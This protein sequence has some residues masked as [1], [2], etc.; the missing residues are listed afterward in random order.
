MFVVF[1]FV[2]VVFESV[3]L[4]VFVVFVFVFVVFVEMTPR[5]RVVT[6]LKAMHERKKLLSRLTMQIKKQI[7]KKQTVRKQQKMWK[8][9]YLC[10]EGSL[11][12]KKRK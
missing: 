8:D 1:V 5:N 4:D 10:G 12:S 9:S 11:K 6:S 3:V 2:L 7:K